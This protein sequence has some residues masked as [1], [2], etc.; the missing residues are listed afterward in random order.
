MTTTTTRTAT[1]MVKINANG[2]RVR[3]EFRIMFLVY[4][5]VRRGTPHK[6]LLENICPR[7]RKNLSY[8]TFIIERVTMFDVIK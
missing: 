2:L 7:V 5:R 6:Y 3:D 4:D 8:Q 1:M